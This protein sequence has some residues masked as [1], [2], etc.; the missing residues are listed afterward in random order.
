MG[1]AHKNTPPEGWRV[2]TITKTVRAKTCRD[3]KQM[4]LIPSG[5]LYTITTN[6]Y[7]CSGFRAGYQAAATQTFKHREDLALLCRKPGLQKHS[8]VASRKLNSLNVGPYKPD[9]EAGAHA[10]CLTT[11][12]FTSNIRGY[13]YLCI[14]VYTWETKQKAILRGPLGINDVVLR[15]PFEDALHHHL[16]QILRLRPPP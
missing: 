12:S 3:Q 15:V 1:G 7:L 2:F 11:T 14:Y 6:I 10:G 16:C 8:W 5:N 13:K 9:E 4:R